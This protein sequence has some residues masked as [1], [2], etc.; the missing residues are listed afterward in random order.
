MIYLDSA[1]T[2]FQKPPAVAAAMTAHTAT[3]RRILRR[4]VLMS[5]PVSIL[6][7]RVLVCCL[8]L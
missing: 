8:L 1:A 4:A 3:I 5:L 2:T 7:L 6:P